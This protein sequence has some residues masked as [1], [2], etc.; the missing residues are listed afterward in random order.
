M[1]PEVREY[2]V[3]IMNMRRIGRKI[4]YILNYISRYERSIV[5]G[6]SINENVSFDHKLDNL[7]ASLTSKRNQIYNSIIPTLESE[8]RAASASR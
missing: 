1:K 6:F 5:S 2:Y 7:K 4:D 8:M 3:L